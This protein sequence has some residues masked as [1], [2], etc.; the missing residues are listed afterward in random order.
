VAGRGSCGRYATRFGLL[1]INQRTKIVCE[2]GETGEKKKEKKRLK[3]RGARII[4]EGDNVTTHRHR[5]FHHRFN[6]IWGERG[7]N[8]RPQD[9]SQL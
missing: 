7:S 2:A 8:S 5:T 4:G 1:E 9:Y 6:Q 3:L